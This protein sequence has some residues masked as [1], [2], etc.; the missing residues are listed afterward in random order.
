MGCETISL[1]PYEQFC[2][3]G[4]HHLATGSESKDRLGKGRS[5]IT[6]LKDQARQPCGCLAAA[7]AHAGEN[8]GLHCKRMQ[9]MQR[10]CRLI[11][12]HKHHGR[13]A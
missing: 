7:K 5:T 10:S 9:V 3:R 8:F 4:H 11:K 1:V 2:P 6:R 12:E 13:S